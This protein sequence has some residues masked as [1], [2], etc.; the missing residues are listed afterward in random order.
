MRRR[1]AQRNARVAAKLKQI[2]LT[3]PAVGAPVDKQPS[4]GK[5]L[6]AEF[7]SALYKPR[8]SVGDLALS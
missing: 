7:S 8:R 5:G 6:W 2:K 3:I 1:T 4:H